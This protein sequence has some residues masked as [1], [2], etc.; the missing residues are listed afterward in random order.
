[1]GLVLDLPFS[2]VEVDR[3]KGLSSLYRPPLVYS[4]K[5]CVLRG[6]GPDSVMVCLVDTEFTSRVLGR[7]TVMDLGTFSP[8]G[9]RVRK[10]FSRVESCRGGGFV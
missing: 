4:G 8:R 10:I 1:M 6:K 7:K 3:Y 9:G 2:R 5:F